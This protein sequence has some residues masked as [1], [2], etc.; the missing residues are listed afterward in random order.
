MTIVPV[1]QVAAHPLVVDLEDARLGESAVGEDSDLRRRCSCAPSI[2]DRAARSPT[3]RWSPARRWRRR[4]RARADRG[5][6]RAPGR[7]RAGGWS[8]RTSPTRRRRADGPRGES[9]RRA[10]RRCG[11]ARSTDRGAAVFLDDQGH[12]G[13]GIRACASARRRPDAIMRR[14]Y[15][16]RASRWC[17]RSRTN[18]TAHAR[19][20][21]RRAVCGTKSR[22]HAGIGIDEVRGRRRDLVVQRQHGEHGLDPRRGPQQVAGHRLGR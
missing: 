12:L 7:G 19:S 16:T 1:G 21:S 10:A 18:S 4:R 13:T 15:G 5:W 8:R 9:A 6:T 20:S 17:R 14:A 3:G 11:C 2:P 22:S